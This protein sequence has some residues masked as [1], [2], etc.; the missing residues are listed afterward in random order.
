MAAG[1]G[2]AVAESKPD[3]RSSPKPNI[4]L[5]FTDDQRADTIGALGNP[6]IKTPN[7]D[8]LAGQS[9][10]FLNGYCFGGN[11]GAVC[12][13]A[14]N[15]LMSGRVFFRYGLN[16]HQGRGTPHAQADLPTLPKSM[17]A[18]GY[19]TY[20]SEKSGTANLPEI[21]KQFDHIQNVDAV[22]AL[23]TGRPARRVVDDAIAFL[24]QR[25][26]ADPFFMYHGLPGPHDPRWSTQEFR[27]LYDPA[28]LP[29]PPSF[30]PV[31]PFDKGDLTIRDECLEAWPRTEA[32]IHGH[33]RDYYSLISSMDYDIG[34]LL[35]VVAELGLRD[36]TIIIFSSD[37]GIALGSHGLMGKQSLYEDVLKVPFFLSG[38]GIKTGKSTAFA[39]LH[40]FF[41][42]ICEL[43]SVSV[44]PGLDGRSLVPVLHGTTNSVRGTAFLAYCDFQRSV[45]DERWKLIRSPRVD[46]TQLFDLKSDP[47]ETNNLANDPAHD[48]DVARMMAALAAEQKQHG[49]DL[50]LTVPHPKP[51]A[52]T[53]PDHKLPTPYPAGGLAPGE[54]V[55]P[56]KQN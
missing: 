7:L 10:V 13:P 24:K 9:F 40:D 49:D 16:N 8:K 51:A 4:L 55:K 38:P 52:W 53:P 25:N 19:E 29:L 35:N 26:G 50:P 21:Q 45:R 34:R 56:V 6:H 46:V 11:S 44:P 54:Q 17:K 47:W 31:H 23:R 41:P 20:Y 42:T 15:E 18:A 36:N 14:R 30:M 33:L 37:Q 5:I 43:A 12:I 39:Y 32:A 28:K 48:K 3:V 22:A 27:D 2:I 1:T